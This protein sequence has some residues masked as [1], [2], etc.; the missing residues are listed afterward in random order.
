QN[1]APVVSVSYGLC[2]AQLSTSDIS[3][4]TTLTQQANTQGQTIV[5]S[6]GDSGP[7]D[8]DYSADPNNPV[9]SATHGYAVDMPASLPDVTAMGGGEFSEGDDTGATQYWSG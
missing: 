3:T 7:A 2:E 1:L 9:K 8:C 6:S 5:A 4:L